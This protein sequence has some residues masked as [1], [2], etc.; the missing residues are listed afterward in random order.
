MGLFSRKKHTVEPASHTTAASAEDSPPLEGPFDIADAPAGERVDFG[1]IQVPPREGMQIALE[2]EQR[3]RRV[4]G[5][6][7]SLSGSAI[8]INAFAAPKSHGLWDDVRASLRESIAQQGGTTETREGTFG[9]ELHARVPLPDEGT[10]RT[11]ATYR[12]MRFVGI[13]GKRWFLRAVISGA[14]L[15]DPGAR[16]AVEEAIRSLVIVRGRAPMA[17]KEV[18]ELTIPEQAAESPQH[19][20]TPEGID[21]AGHGPSIAVVG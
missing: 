17:P 2:M 8:Q 16:G 1:A 21:P 11:S 15:R 6:T 10:G 18:I 12:P 9:T 3:S 19:T 13:D 7:L 20:D 5:L 4:S 14:A